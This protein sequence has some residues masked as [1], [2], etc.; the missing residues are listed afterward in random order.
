M[1]EELVFTSPQ[2]KHRHYHREEL[3]EQGRERYHA[4]PG[5]YILKTKI[6]NK[7]NRDRHNENERQY[8]QR[9]KERLAQE[10]A[11]YRLDH[12]DKIKIAS[13]KYN[14]THSE[15]LTSD[16]IIR[17]TR[18]RSVTANLS[19]SEWNEIKELF[20]NVCAYCGSVRAL[21][22]DHF[23]PLVS[24]GPYTYKNVVPACKSCNSS[25]NHRDFNIWYPGFRHYDPER[26]AKILEHIN[27]T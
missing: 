25:K 26:E 20:G 22:R 6:W 4:D 24:G 3:N 11:Q 19:P 2:A 17:R 23:I 16:K 27:S 5:R 8:Y 18:K 14:S 15:K 7:E 12:P 21:C 1:S 13:R 9:N 10:K